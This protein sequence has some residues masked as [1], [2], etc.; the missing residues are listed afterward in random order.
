MNIT[1]F[2]VKWHHFQA[3]LEVK[4]VRISNAIQRCCDMV[5]FSFHCIH[6]EHECAKL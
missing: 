3:Q 2:E 5:H 4:A 6:L 1:Q